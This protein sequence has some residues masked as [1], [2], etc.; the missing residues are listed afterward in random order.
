[1]RS[2]CSVPSGETLAFSMLADGCSI[3]SLL[4]GLLC[5]IQTVLCAALD[6]VELAAD[7]TGLDLQHYRDTSPYLA[8]F[9]Y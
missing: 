3:Y 4:T 2:R 6:A 5:F 9:I 8:I 1:M 7:C